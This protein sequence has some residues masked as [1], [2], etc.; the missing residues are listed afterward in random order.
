MVIADW[1]PLFPACVYVYVCTL[2]KRKD[3]HVEREKVSR[4]ERCCIVYIRFKQVET[5]MRMFC[6]FAVTSSIL[7]LLL[8]CSK[9]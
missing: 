2:S 3:W 7:L 6:S 9:L 1:T 4:V 8:L 5:I